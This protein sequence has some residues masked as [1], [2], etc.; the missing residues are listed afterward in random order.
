ML[1][2]AVLSLDW[3]PRLGRTKDWCSSSTWRYLGANFVWM[4]VWVLVQIGAVARRKLLTDTFVRPLCRNGGRWRGGRAGLPRL[5]VICRGIRLTTEEISRITSVRVS[6]RCVAE[7]CSARFINSTET[8]SS[9][10]LLTPVALGLRIRPQASNLN[11]RRYLLSCRTAVFLI[12]AVSQN[13]RLG[14]WCGRRRMELRDP[15]ESAF[16]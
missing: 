10:D 8:V 15:R 2:P 1:T 5:C 9:T 6:K 11:P 12:S 7:H 3:R 16:H 14:F 4:A 13:S